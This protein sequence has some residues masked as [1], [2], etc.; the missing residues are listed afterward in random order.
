MFYNNNNSHPDR[1]G[2]QVWYADDASACADL[3]ALKDWLSGLLNE[4]PKYG[5]SPKPSKS[6]TVVNERS[7]ERANALF[8]PLGVKVVTSHRFLGGVIG[9]NEGQM[10]FLR[11]RVKEWSHILNQLSEI[12][13][14]QPQA[15]YAALTK[16]IQNKWQFVQRLVPNCQQALTDIENLL[17]NSILPAIFGCEI[18]PQERDIFSLPTRYGGL[19][20]LNPTETCESLYSTSRK[21]TDVI[22]SSLKEHTEFCYTDHLDVIAR[23]HADL[24]KEKELVFEEKFVSIVT[25]LNS[26]Q[27]RSLQRVK[28][29]KMSSWLNVLPVVR[30]NFDLSAVEFRD[31]LAIRY[32]KPLL[33]IPSDC[34]GCGATLSLSHALSCRKGGLVIQR[35]NEI[36]D[37]FGD[38]A[39]LAWSQVKKEPIVKE[40]SSS[41]PALI[42][43]LAVRGV[44]SPQVDVLFDIRVTDT[45][46]SSY[47][48]QTPMAI[49]KRAEAQKKEK[50][51][52]ACEERRA[53]FTPLCV[54]VDGMLGLEASR[55]LKQLS[56]QLAYKWERS[57]S[58]IMSWVRTQL[59]F[60]ILRASILCLRG[61]RTKWR[62]VNMI[63]GA[64]LSLIMS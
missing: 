52:K 42:A 53:L 33:N 9:D 55:F 7:I 12:A 57:Y 23:V 54:T 60:S 48:D 43:D 18:S 4:G 8:G 56:E 61:S 27:R 26:E 28:D 15:A 39:A 58:T 46:A 41:N 44:W 30:H 22:I 25:H 21:I 13:I 19:H 34:D 64:P 38:L 36:R 37:A 16:S 32:R 59:T 1:S 2:T 10:E 62:S 49:L 6:Y 14:E 47:G 40:P 24:L 31:A 11:S 63:D 5:Y 17:F 20:V 35:H 29:A 50:Y 3:E 45:D 51:L